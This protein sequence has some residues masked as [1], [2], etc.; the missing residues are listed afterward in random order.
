VVARAPCARLKKSANSCSR[1]PASS[2]LSCYRRPAEAYVSESDKVYTN[3]EEMPHLP[4]AAGLAPVVEAVQCRLVVSPRTEEGRIFVKLT[5]GE[6]GDVQDVH[7]LKGLST[8]VDSTVLGAVRRLPRFEPGR[9]NL[10]PVKARLTVPIRVLRKYPRKPYSRKPDVKPQ[11]VD[12][13]VP[14]LSDLA[15]G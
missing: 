14:D 11:P 13:A 1:L 2:L 5:V 3:A 7:L 12:P 15:P 6:A 10:R 4:G 8:A 9:Q